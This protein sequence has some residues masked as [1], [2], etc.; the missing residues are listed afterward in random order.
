MADHKDPTDRAHLWQRADAVDTS[1]PVYDF[2]HELP[3]H[4]HKADGLWKQVN[5]PDEFKAAIDEG[6]ALLPVIAKAV[7]AIEE[8]VAEVKAAVTRG[9]KKAD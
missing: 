9:R 5:T 6:W 8:A 1:A 3:R 2:P 4:L 7:E